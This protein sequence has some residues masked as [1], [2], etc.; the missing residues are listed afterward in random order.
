MESGLG[1]G[2]DFGDGA[3][4][5]FLL[6]FF[7]G[8]ADA[9]REASAAD[10]GLADEDFNEE[11]LAVV[12]S[13]LG[14]DGVLGLAVIAGL[15]QFLKRGF[16]VADA[17]AVG[18]L[19]AERGRGGLDDFT[20]DEAARGFNAA[21]EI[22]RGHDGFNAVGEQSVFFAASAALFS[23]AEEHVR[24]EV[25]ARGYLTEMFAADQLGAQTSERPFVQLGIATA[26]ILSDEEADDG[27]AEKFELLIVGA[28]IIGSG[29]FRFSEPLLIGKGAVSERAGEQLPLREFM[30]Q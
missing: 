1:T 11:A 29:C 10:A 26:E 6:G 4:G 8:A 23:A 22:E 16:V 18:Q 24:A 5:G 3:A 14:F 9:A 7:S 28:G 19:F 20:K 17:A 30:P 15:K 27:V 12:G 21:I 25:E 2:A 13:A